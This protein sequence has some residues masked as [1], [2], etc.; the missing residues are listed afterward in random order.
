M[1]YFLFE[2]SEYNKNLTLKALFYILINF[3]K[4]I[5]HFQKYSHLLGIHIIKRKI[6]KK[7]T[8]PH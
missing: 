1:N 8:F 2:K 5:K 6:R 3:D 4:R 7:V